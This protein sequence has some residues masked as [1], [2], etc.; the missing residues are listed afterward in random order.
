ML[1]SGALSGTALACLMVAAEWLKNGLP[2]VVVAAG[3]DSDGEARYA[4]LTGTDYY[5]FLIRWVSQDAAGGLFLGLLGGA[6]TALVS[7]YWSGITRLSGA[8]LFWAV[9]GAGGG[10]LLGILVDS[11]DGNGL[12]GVAGFVIA[13]VT[14]G[15]AFGA[16]LIV[17]TRLI[18]LILGR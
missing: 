10:L 12:V 6:V 3:R 5:V 2:H 7:L 11:G 9:F 15:A 14:V 1:I 8:A 16:A 13:G 18:S 17:F 4:D